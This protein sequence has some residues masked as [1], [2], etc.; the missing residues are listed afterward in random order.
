MVDVSSDG[1]AHVVQE[2]TCQ[3]EGK[4]RHLRLTFPAQFR[5][6]RVTLNRLTER[7]A[8][9]V[10]PVDDIDTSSEAGELTLR[11]SPRAEDET[12][13]Y[14]VDL[15]VQ[16]AVRRYDDAAHLCVPVFGAAPG[17]VEQATVELRLPGAART[18]FRLSD[19]LGNTGTAG[20]DRRIGFL[21]VRSM[22]RHDRLI[23]D[24]VTDPDV[25]E[26]VPLRPGLMDEVELTPPRRD[27]R[28]PP[29]RSSPARHWQLALVAVLLPLVLLLALYLLYGREPRVRYEARYEREPPAR[30]PPLAVP[31]IMRQQPDLTELPAQTLDATLAT[32][33]DAAR[34]G[35]LEVL[36]GDA[37]TGEG[38]GFRLAHPD[39]LEDLDG[40]SRRVVDYYFGSVSEGRDFVTDGDVRRHANMQPGS[41][42]S[43]LNQMSQEGRD[44]WRK[45]L[46]VGFLEPR[47]S[48]AYHFLRWIAPILTGLAW[49]FVP[50]RL[51]FL[52]YDLSLRLRLVLFVL[53]FLLSRMAY[54]HMGRVI[55]RWSPPAYYE[56]LRWQ[57]Y[58]RFLVDFS[59]IREAPVELS[60][61]WQEHYVYAVALGIGAKFMQGLS[62]LATTS[63]WAVELLRWRSPE[64]PA[65]SLAGLRPEP[66][67][68]ATLGH[69][70]DQILEGFRSGSGIQGRR[71]DRAQ[72]LL[73]RLVGRRW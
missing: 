23:V 5:G 65:A 69:S 35:V 13:H 63:N 11:W 27:L 9:R 20:P 42:W 33:L 57:N 16:G 62:N 34:K 28:S 43:W 17:P 3:F 1:T 37:R 70:I 54:A 39:R 38:R 15:T 8:L 2:L 25:F 58:R 44:W 73:S 64:D 52:S 61:I 7:A 30:I 22:R 48:I 12:R 51:A 36:F 50:L 66:R 31:A 21:T 60:A 46:G 4:C 40:L 19:E 68:G 56:H 26:G 72:P 67:A 45:N 18:T 59:A 41:F 47:G 6:S 55:L 53:T 49:F 14:V 10:W 24:A 71:F 32:L 29:F